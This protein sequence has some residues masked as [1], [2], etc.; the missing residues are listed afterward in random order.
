MRRADTVEST[1]RLESGKDYPHPLCERADLLYHFYMLYWNRA[2]EANMRAGEPI[3]TVEAHTLG[4]IERNP[5]INV[6]GLA[7]VW[8]R[9]KGAISQTVAKLERKGCV[10]RRKQLG[11]A[12][13]VLLYPTKKGARL[14][15]AHRLRDAD[16]IS[17]VINGLLRSGC[18]REE[19]E[20]FFR[21]AEKYVNS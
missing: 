13:T 16:M 1:V 17:A 9:T 8:N 12:K 19:I 5:G 6:S 20:A 11:N 2:A 4:I 14:L 18:T 10:V 7:A 15:R 3:S 21:V